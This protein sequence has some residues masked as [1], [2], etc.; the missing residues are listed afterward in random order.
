MVTAGQRFAL[1]TVVRV[2][3]Y[4]QYELPS[5][6]SKPHGYSEHT[7]LPIG[8]LLRTVQYYVPCVQYP[9]DRPSMPSALAARIAFTK[10]RGTRGHPTAWKG[11]AAAVC[12]RDVQRYHL[13][14]CIH[15]TYLPYLACSPIT[16]S[17]CDSARTHAGRPSNTCWTWCDVRNLHAEA[18]DAV[19]CMYL[20]E[21]E[22]H[23]VVASDRLFPS[24]R[25]LSSTANGDQSSMAHGL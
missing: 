25:G 12:H 1:S 21:V 18:T 14:H 13:S 19:H 20:S 8:R 24:H 4:L 23:I 11:A 10:D 3:Y 17:E 16:Y 7:T 2:Q 5:A 9:H 15:S 22:Q 6:A